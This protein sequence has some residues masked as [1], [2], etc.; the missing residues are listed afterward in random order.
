[1]R[2]GR[3]SFV[4]GVL[5]FSA[6]AVLPLRAAS[7]CHGPPYFAT[8]SSTVTGSN[9][10]YIA[11]GD[12]NGDGIT[13]LAVTNSFR[14]VSAGAGSSVSILLGHGDGTF[15]TPVNYGAGPEPRSIAMG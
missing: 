5:G 6:L 7:D 8:A 4:L 14:E 9:P 12:F 15:A 11:T 13:D 3:R 2:T 10:T 1:M